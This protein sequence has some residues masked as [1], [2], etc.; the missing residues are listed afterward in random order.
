MEAKITLLNQPKDFSLAAII[1]LDTIHEN[2]LEAA[3]IGHPSLIAPSEFSHKI[4]HSQK[5]RDME[6]VADFV[7]R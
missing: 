4:Y 3:V 6:S 5:E 2:G 1:D 7:T